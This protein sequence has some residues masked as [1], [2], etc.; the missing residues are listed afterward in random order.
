MQQ[1]V[2]ESYFR[3]KSLGDCRVTIC[4]DVSSRN[5]NLLLAFRKH[6]TISQYHKKWAIIKIAQTERQAGKLEVQN[7]SPKF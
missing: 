2:N 6:T 5:D 1:S 4:S 3:R 7:L